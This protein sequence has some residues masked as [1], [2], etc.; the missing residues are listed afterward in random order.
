MTEQLLKEKAE[1][2]E[3]SGRAEDMIKCKP[4]NQD[5]L[6]FAESAYEDVYWKAG[7]YNLFMVCDSPRQA[8]FRDL[9]D[10]FTFRLC[11]R[12]EQAASVRS[13]ILILASS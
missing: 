7:G 1:L 3:A 4:E 6:V 11:R 12:D 8:A 2:A 10:G 9:P 13:C 5:Y